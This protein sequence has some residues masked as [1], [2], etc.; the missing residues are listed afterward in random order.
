MK[1]FNGGKLNPIS[2]NELML[3]VK[4]GD[5]DKLGLLYE[6]YNKNL[7]GYFWRLS[8]SIEV[9]E[10]LVQTVFYRILKNRKQYRGKGKFTSWMYQIAHNLW[11][12]FYRKNKRLDSIEDYKHWHLKDGLSIDEQIDREEQLRHLKYAMDQL[13]AEKKEVLILSKY[14]GLKYNEI[15]DLLKTTEGA[16]KT[17]IFRALNE[18]R[19][20]YMK[21]EKLK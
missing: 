1:S 17:R 3:R 19:E 2:D 16:I 12:D 4:T 21:I 18:L 5:V 14:Q 8:G 9:S 6:R 10:D 15:A 11:A 7:F 13:S 20:L